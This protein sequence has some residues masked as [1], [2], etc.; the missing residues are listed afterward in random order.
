[1]P[2]QRI[3]WWNDNSRGVGNAMVN[4][5]S[6]IDFSCSLKWSNNAKGPAPMPAVPTPVNNTY[7][8]SQGKPLSPSMTFEDSEMPTT[9]RQVR[10]ADK[11]NMAKKT[12]KEKKR[13]A[14]K[15]TNS[16]QV[17]QQQQSI[18]QQQQSLIQQQHQALQAMQASGNSA[19]PTQMIQPFVVVPYS[20]PMQSLYHYNNGTLPIGDI[21]SDY[22]RATGTLPGGNMNGA[23]GDVNGM[24]GMMQQPNQMMGAPALPA[25]EE[26]TEPTPKEKEGKEKRLN[27]PAI[28]TMILIAVF[29]LLPLIAK[30]LFPMMGLGESE[31]FM[32][33]QG[34]D[35]Y[36]AIK[37]II[38]IATGEE[39][40]A[41]SEALVGNGLLAISAALYAIVV[42][43]SL[44]MIMSGRLPLFVRILTLLALLLV[45]ASAIVV[46]VSGG[47][48]TM[49]IMTYCMVGVALLIFLFS[50]IGKRKR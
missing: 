18:I 43:L 44:I 2:V 27:V 14:K 42:I 48:A 38:A 5:S 32:D 39:A 6:D 37:K 30:A 26:F 20:T 36:S 9:S 31:L 45:V 46:I 19:Q 21:D 23:M 1:M 15:K 34:L 4:G 12:A 7:L 29:A 33:K 11:R 17:Y 40:F 24:P 25:M 13:E 8:N 16:S 35:L 41:F 3:N 22:M 28:I 47:F 50:L 49:G 10:R